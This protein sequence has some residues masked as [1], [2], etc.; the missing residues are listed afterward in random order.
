MSGP[1]IPRVLRY[2]DRM[3]S[4]AFN[5]SIGFLDSSPATPKTMDQS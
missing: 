5:R 2:L 4:M 1:L 3:S